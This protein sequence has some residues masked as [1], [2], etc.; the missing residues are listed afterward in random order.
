MPEHFRSTREVLEDHVRLRLAGPFEEDLRR[1]HS[2]NV[3]L[4]TVNSSEGGHDA[5]RN[6]ARRSSNQL[7]N[8]EFRIVKM[9]IA[10]P[11]V[12]LIWSA[13]SESATAVEG[14]DSFSIDHGKITFQSHPLCSD[15]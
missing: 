5:L 7:P 12:L 15:K 3:A 11:H 1:N 13:T 4:L 8:A 6:S 2:P 10:G 14:A 9:Q